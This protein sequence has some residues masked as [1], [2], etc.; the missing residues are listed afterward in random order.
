MRFQCNTQPMHTFTIPS[1]YSQTQWNCFVNQ[2][3][4]YSLYSPPR[5]QPVTS[6]MVPTPISIATVIF[7]LWTYFFHF[8]KTFLLVKSIPTRYYL[9]DYFRKIQLRN[10]FWSNFQKNYSSE[11][12]VFSWWGLMVRHCIFGSCGANRSGT[13]HRSS[14]GQTKRVCDNNAKRRPLLH[15]TFKSYRR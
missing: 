8:E 4:R 11:E 13:T 12:C 3:Q 6:G 2:T 9:V 15:F 14:V 10:L 1:Q 5:I 7:L